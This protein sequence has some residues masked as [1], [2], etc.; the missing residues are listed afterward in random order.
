M[1]EAAIQFVH[2]Y[3]NIVRTIGANT[4][5]VSPTPSYG[6]MIVFAIFPLLFG[7]GFFFF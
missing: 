6:Y 3:D 5:L 7:N 4:L 1:D 2:Y